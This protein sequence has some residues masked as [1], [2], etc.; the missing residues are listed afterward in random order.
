MP[1]P[2][3]R[4]SHDVVRRDVTLI[5]TCSGPGD[6]RRAAV[7]QGCDVAPTATRLR[8]DRSMPSRSGRV[9]NSSQPESISS[10][11]PGA[12][13]PPVDI[14]PGIRLLRTRTLDT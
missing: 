10:A 8:V 4:N 13:L 5:R 7:P 2:G 12:P 3:G 1:S 14:M 6:G 11:G 9:V